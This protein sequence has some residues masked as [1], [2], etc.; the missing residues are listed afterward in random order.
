MAE[1]KGIQEKRRR[2]RFSM[3]LDVSCEV[4]E[5]GK[6]DNIQSGDI[7]MGG[8]RVYA[9]EKLSAGDRLKLNIHL[10]EDR[11]LDAMA[12][13]KWCRSVLEMG[14]LLDYHYAL[15]LEFVELGEEY[16]SMLAKFLEEAVLE[17]E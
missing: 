11:V 8:I 3:A 9:H 13:V 16:S 14:L 7:S 6:R 4:I 17:I 12:V 15:G 1:K 5:S 10:G 2:F